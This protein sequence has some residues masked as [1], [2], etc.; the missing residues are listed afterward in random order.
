MDHPRIQ[1]L[2]DDRT[3]VPVVAWAAEQRRAIADALGSLPSAQRQVIE[4]AYFRGLS[5]QEIAVQLNRPLGTIK[6]RV[7]LGLQKLGNLLTASGIA[8]EDAL[9][10]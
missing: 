7:R 5:H 1:E 3:D 6:T 9:E 10:A 4:L 2:A 8:A